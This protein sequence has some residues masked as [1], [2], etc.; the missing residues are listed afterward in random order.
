MASDFKVKS[1]A[2]ALTLLELFIDTP[3][4]GVSEIAMRLDLNKSNVSDILSTF[5]AMGYVERQKSTGKYMLGAKLLKYAYPIVQQMEIYRTIYP[6]MLLLAEH[7][8]EMVYLA[9]PYGTEALYLQ[10][11]LP[12]TN[13]G[14]YFI[15]SILG[16]KA[17]L[18]CTAIGK[19]M[20]S[21]IPEEEWCDRIPDTMKRYTNN[22]ITNREVLYAELRLIK[23]QGFAVDNMEHEKDVRCVGVSLMNDEGSLTAGISVSGPAHRFSQERCTQIAQQL[24]K[25]KALI[26]IRS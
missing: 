23:E 6:H 25:Q 17:P 26:F 5:A 15:R 21:E 24:Q 12:S 1:L 19:A 16:E 10:N 2:K 22:T 4:C 18:Y 7:L 13:P 3:V 14:S 11:A 8:K 9:I 20:L